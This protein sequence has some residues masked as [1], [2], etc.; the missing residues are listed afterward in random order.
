MHVPAAVNGTYQLFVTGTASGTFTLIPEFV[1]S[2]GSIQR[3][4]FTGIT[5]LGS[6]ATYQSQYDATPGTIPQLAL[7][8]SSSGTVPPNQVSATASGL[9]YSRVSQTFNGTITIKNIASAAVN[10]PLQI[11][12]TSLPAGVTLNNATNSFAGNPYLTV[13][14]VT[15]LPPGQSATVNLQFKNSST[16]AITFTPVIYSGSLN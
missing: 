1:A 6:V 7:I 4:S 16:V 13:P 8:A 2:D 5:N 12:F 14:T 15:S 9:A 3:T 10:G 11:V